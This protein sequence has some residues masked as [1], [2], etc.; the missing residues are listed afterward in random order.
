MNKKWLL[1]LIVLFLTPFAIIAQSA[2]ANK[3]AGINVAV[4]DFKNNPLS[5][6]II[7][8]KSKVTAKEYQGLTDSTGK[9]SMRLPVGD[10]Y[11][12]L[13]WGFNDST[14]YTFRYSNAKR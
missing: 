3:D 10:T 8:F 6:E 5:H 1:S 14:S 13:I 2:T 12:V 7:I 4:T 11:E 9:F